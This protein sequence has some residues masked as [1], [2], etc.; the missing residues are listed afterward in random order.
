MAVYSPALMLQGD[1]LLATVY[2]GLKA[3]L[4]IGIWGAVFT[5]FLQAKLSWWERI[6]GFA[7]GASLILATPI[8]DEIGF[9]LSAIFIAQ[10]VWRARRAEVATA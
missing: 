2:V 8:S 6:L 4:A 5:G 9:A 3:L 7:A 1:S 10:H